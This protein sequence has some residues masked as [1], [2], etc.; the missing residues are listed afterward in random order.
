MSLHSELYVGWVYVIGGEQPRVG[1]LGVTQSFCC[2]GR[3]YLRSWTTMER[4][5]GQMEYGRAKG[6][7]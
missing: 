3:P 7:Q 6:I 4:L 5:V 1:K 2:F